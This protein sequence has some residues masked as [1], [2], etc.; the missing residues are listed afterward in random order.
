MFFADIPIA[1]LL[2][3]GIRFYIKVDVTIDLMRSQ[4]GYLLISMRIITCSLPLDLSLGWQPGI[5]EAAADWDEG[6]DK[7]DNKGQDS[8][9]SKSSPW[10]YEML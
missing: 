10:M 7:F 4:Q 5:Q 9:L 2:L 8:H 6:W 1:I 3:F